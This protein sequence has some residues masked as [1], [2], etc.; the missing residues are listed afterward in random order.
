ME[1]SILASQFE[2]VRPRRHLNR[3]VE[4]VLLAFGGADPQNLT[5]KALRALR[6]LEFD[7]EVTVVV[8]PA[9]A[10]PPVDL[11]AESLLGSVLATV[12]N[13]ATVMNGPISR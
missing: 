3:R 1:N 2:V 13:M 4:R 10:H 9:Y 5:A 8:G 12:P 7:G 6:M 11:A